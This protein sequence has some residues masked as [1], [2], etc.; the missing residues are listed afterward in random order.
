MHSCTKRW[1]VYCLLGLVFGVADWHFLQLL[2]VIPW[3]RLSGSSPVGQLLLLPVI[4][5]LNWGIWLVPVVPV[6]IHEA[7]RSASVWLSAVA[8]M[9]VWCTAILAYYLYYTILIAFWGLPHMESLLVLREHSATFWQDWSATFRSLILGQVAEWIIVAV[10][11]GAIVGAGSG[12]IYL[13]T[14]R[15]RLE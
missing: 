3:Q 4:V 5:G 8:A 10:V 6:A 15:R 2:V 11:G 14:R 9:V 13:Y 1:L 12:A 7:R